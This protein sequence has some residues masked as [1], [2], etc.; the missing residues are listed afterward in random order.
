M[1]EATRE[2]YGGKV[3]TLVEGDAESAVVTVRLTKWSPAVAS[4]DATDESFDATVGE[5]AIGSCVTGDEEA[6]SGDVDDPEAD[7]LVSVGR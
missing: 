7:I 3:K 4:D 2:M 5:D 6:A 1:I